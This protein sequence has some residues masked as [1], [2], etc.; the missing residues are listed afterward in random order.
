EKPSSLEDA[1]ASLG[2]AEAIEEGFL[3]YSTQL[4][5][6]Y[7]RRLL[8]QRPLFGMSLTSAEEAADFAKGALEELTALAY[9]V[10]HPAG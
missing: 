2:A 10:A 8:I 6:E 9:T 4:E 3:D 5:E 7:E 1:L